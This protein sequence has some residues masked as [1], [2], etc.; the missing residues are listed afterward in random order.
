M[1]QGIFND[2]CHKHGLKS[3]AISAGIFA[4]NGGPISAKAVEALREFGIDISNY[5]SKTIE[6]IN[7]EKMDFL[8][9]M[10]KSHKN[11]LIDRYP[12]IGEKI[13]LLN[14][15]AFYEKKDIEDP[16]GGDLQVYKSAR[17]EIHRAILEIIRREIK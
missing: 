10:G 11:F 8:L 9:V 1:A 6:S 17:D 3:K 5:K 16:F 15:Y 2:L 14:E 7:L 12:H 13:F 4:E